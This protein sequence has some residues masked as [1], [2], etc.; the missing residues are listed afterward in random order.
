VVWGISIEDKN[1]A[2][3]EIK[4]RGFPNFITII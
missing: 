4:L 1:Y 3:T 2:I